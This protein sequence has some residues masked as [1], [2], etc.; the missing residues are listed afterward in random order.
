MIAVCIL[1]VGKGG[2]YWRLDY[3]IDGK[4][5]TLALGVYPDI[6]LKV[7]RRSATKRGCEISK[8]ID[9][10]AKRQME[11]D[12]PTDTFE[13]VARE[14]FD[15]FK[16][17]WVGSHSERII[18]RLERDIFPWIGSRDNR[19][20]KA[21]DLLS[22]LRRIEGRGAVETAHRATQ[23]C[24]QVFRYGVATGRTDR[25]ITADLRGAIPP[26]KVKN[27]AAITEPGR[28]AELLRA[29]DGYMGTFVHALRLR[30][31]PLFFVRPGELRHAQWVDFDLDVAE[32]RYHVEQ[33][34][35]TA[36]RAIRKTS[37]G[38]SARA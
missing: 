20:I 23:N 2:R 38:S 3:R 5:K 22:V 32:W 29:I 13:S 11:K 4:R 6:S 26:S 14:W 21:P 7:A 8:G 27:H 9:P 19:T 15:K 31:S 1:L 36:Y 35:A 16:S 25:D 24:G 17:Q 37:N 18:R 28:I 12:T 34:K 33:D 10:L 30:L